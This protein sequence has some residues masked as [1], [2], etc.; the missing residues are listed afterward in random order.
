MYKENRELRD[1]PAI[2]DEQFL[3]IMEVGN[4]TAEARKCSLESIHLSMRIHD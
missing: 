1:N 4:I 2:K 3:A